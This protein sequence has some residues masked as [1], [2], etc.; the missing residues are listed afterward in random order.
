MSC[1]FPQG[2]SP[3]NDGFN[4]S[5]EL[6]NYTVDRLEIYNRNGMLV[7]S[8]DNYTDEWYGQSDDNEELPVGTYFYVM[9]YQGSKERTGWVY[10]NR[11]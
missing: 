2:I 11:E 10:I 5:F 9:K 1:I 3:N 8:K 4:D 6:S 7:Y